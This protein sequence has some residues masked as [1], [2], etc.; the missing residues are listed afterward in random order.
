MSSWLIR[1]LNL[2]LTFMYACYM[3]DKWFNRK[4]IGSKMVN[5]RQMTLQLVPLLLCLLPSKKWC[6]GGLL[7][8]LLWGRK[9]G[10]ENGPLCVTA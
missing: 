10:Q 4:E 7:R 2:W 5:F 8:K 3:F 1:I 9:K 6:S